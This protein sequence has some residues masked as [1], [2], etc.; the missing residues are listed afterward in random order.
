MGRKQPRQRQYLYCIIACLSLISG[1]TAVSNFI[2]EQR[3]MAYL[4]EVKTYTDQGDFELARLKNQAVLDD[5]SDRSPA[6]AALYSMA[7]IYAD[8]LNPDKDYRFSLDLLTQLVRNFPESHFAGNARTLIN[9]FED[10]LLDNWESRIH[11]K[12]S[13]HLIQS[14]RFEEA[15]QKNI[16]IIEQKDKPALTDA[17]LFSLGL[18]Y[19]DPANPERDYSRSL[20]YFS[21]LMS[22]FPDS[23]F[24]WDSRI[25]DGILGDDLSGRERRIHLQ[26]ARLL[27]RQGNFADAIRLNQQ[28]INSQGEHLAQDAALY[29]LG[30]IY[31]DRRNPGYDFNKALGYFMQL[32]TS[33][34]ETPLAEGARIWIGLLEKQIDDQKSSIWFQNAQ[35]M[36]K[37]QRFETLLKEAQKILTNSPG[38]QPADAALYS[39]AL[40][41]L[42]EANPRQDHKKAAA[43]LKRLLKEFPASVYAEEARIWSH[44]LATLEQTLRVDLEIDKKTKALRR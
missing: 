36:L 22:D 38:R 21:R 28:I 7:L 43:L 11:L 15:V 8:P 31:A 13:Q 40:V 14:G 19:A 35:L 20:S 10:G 30:Q 33:Y 23:T 32:T 39:S 5:A 41:Y 44:L 1:C 24:N 29:S 3:S 6:D 16:Q 17:A 2:S 37:K 34:P 9:I 18:I 42:H 27:T 25:W 12:Q 26:Q 4:R